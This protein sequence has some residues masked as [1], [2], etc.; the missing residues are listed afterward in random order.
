MPS[1]ML[2]V[3]PREVS[4]TV[5]VWNL[6]YRINRSCTLVSDLK[7]F[8]VCL[9]ENAGSFNLPFVGEAHAASCDTSQLTALDQLCHVCTA[10][11]IANRAN[12]RQGRALVDTA[13]KVFGYDDVCSLKSTL[14]HF[15]YPVVFG[16]VYGSL[17]LD[18]DTTLTAFMS[19]VIRT[20]VASAVRLDRIGPIEAQKIVTELQ[21]LIPEIIHRNKT[22][23]AADARVTFPLTDIMQNCHDKLFSK[24]FYS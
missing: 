2:K 18:L 21:R 10:N 13:S 20:S 11:H 24:L 8:V 19:G 5:W 3:F 7:N 15:H 6:L 14:K 9:L 23:S 22:S 12:T 17:G 1:V 4:L 16:A